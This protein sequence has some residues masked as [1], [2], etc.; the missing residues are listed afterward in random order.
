MSIGDGTVHTASV[1]A[2]PAWSAHGA[3]QPAI[4]DFVR[5]HLDPSGCGLLPGGDE[6]PGGEDESALR[7]GEPLRWAPG[8]R[9]GVAALH[10]AAGVTDTDI[11]ELIALIGG[12]INSQ[13]SPA[14]YGELYDRL[15]AERAVAIADELVGAVAR[16][17]LPPSGVAELGRRLA[18]TGRNAEAVKVGIALLG[19]CGAVEDRDLLLTLGRHEEFTLF[20]AAAL[21]G[22]EPQPDRILWSL[23]RS[24]DGW[25]R[26]HAVKRLW[27]TGDE[28]IQDWIVRRGFRNKVMNEYL[29]Y[30]A[31]TT[32]RLLDRLEAD[33]DDELVGA[34]GDIISALTAGGPAP[35]IDD[36]PDAPQLLDAY[37]RLI[38][39][40]AAQPDHM[41]V[42]HEIR[43]FL[44]G[45]DRWPERYQRGWSAN[46]R[47]GLLSTCEQI[48]SRH[49]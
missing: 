41:A 38:S 10:V 21:R 5:A 36:Y 28:E 1:G 44:Q 46:Q 40:R 27:C 14:E 37:L 9:D 2:E 47:A 13:F 17:G 25:G 18:G 49:Q 32:G 48:M 22:S 15:R 26:I 12:A 11:G 23:A 42:V 3:D 34:A 24:V 6:L 33:P 39:D 31:A 29:T 7:P 45:G 43:G 19:V 8:A 4:L 30:I 16:S 35:D 20:C